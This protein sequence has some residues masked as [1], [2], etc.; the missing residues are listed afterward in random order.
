MTTYYLVLNG[1]P[2][3]GKSTLAHVAIRAFV[4]KAK[5]YPESVAAPIKQLAS[6]LLG[7]AYSSINKEKKLALLNNSSPRDFLIHIYQDYLRHKYGRDF[8][9]RALVHR[10][11]NRH[12]F[13]RNQVFVIDDGGVQEEFDCFPRDQTC[14]VRIMRPGFSFGSDSRAYL[15]NPDHTIMNDADL[16]KIESIMEGI[17]YD[18]VFKWNLMEKE[19]DREDDRKSKRITDKDEEE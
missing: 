15:P 1:P 13:H 2:K 16:S 8:L 11:T 19:D 10:C 12:Q 6:A 7:Q 18:L 5:S 14:L 9:G 4:Y 3:V 17:V